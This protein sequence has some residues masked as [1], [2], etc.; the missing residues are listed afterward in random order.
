MMRPLTLIAVPLTVMAAAA[1]GSSNHAATTITVI[2]QAA[3]TS[4]PTQTTTSTPTPTT[5]S[6]PTG[7]VHTVDIAAD[8]TGLL[9]YTQTS[10]SATAGKV[11]IGFTNQSPVPH[12]VV[13]INSGNKILG[14]T[15][16]FSSGGKSFTVTLTAGTYTYYCSVPGHRQ[17]GMQGTLTVS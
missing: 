4:T 13:L 12:N 11:T 7:A 1:C 15:P 16:V 17:A 5:T 10:L 2:T 14:Q 3:T 8:P 6:A 9:K